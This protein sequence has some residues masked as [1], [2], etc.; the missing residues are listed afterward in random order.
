VAQAAKSLRDLR[1]AEVAQLD[2]GLE[3]GKVKS[4]GFRADIEALPADV[5]E[6][7]NR[8]RQR[9]REPRES[10]GAPDRQAVSAPV[11]RAPVP[12]AHENGLESVTES[13]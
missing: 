7:G 1:V 13:S 12:C 11:C 5:R 4:I 2:L 10:L 8:D 9:T 3:D 6:H